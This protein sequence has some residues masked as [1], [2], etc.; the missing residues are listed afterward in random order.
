MVR[1]GEFDKFAEG[2]KIWTPFDSY[3]MR[4]AIADGF[5]LNPLENLVAVSSKMYFKPPD[6]ELRGF[7]D[8]T[9][10][11]EVQPEGGGTGIDENDKQ[12][13]IRKKSIYENEARIEA[14]SKFVVNI[15]VSVVYRAIRGKDG[16]GWGKA[17]LAVSSIKAAQRYKV[18][19]AEYFEKITRE[20]K[21]KSFKDAPVYVVYSDQ[22]YESA[23]NFNEGLAEKKVLENFAIKKNGIIIV[24]DKLQTG[25]DE[26]KLHTLFLDKEIAGINAIQTISRVNRK[27]KNKHDCRI[28]DFSYKNVNI[29]NI[30]HAYKLFSNVVDSDFA[31]LACED[32][33]KAYYRDLK[34]TTV[35]KATFPSFSKY[36]AEKE[37]IDLVLQ[38][39]HHFVDYIRANPEAAQCLK[40]KVYRYFRTLNTIEHILVFDPKLSEGVFKDFWHKFNIQYKNLNST[41]ENID[42]VA[43]YFDNKSGIIVPEDYPEEQGSQLKILSEPRGV[44][45]EGKDYKYDILRVIEE[46][47]QEEEA[48]EELIKD[49]AE[50]IDWLFEYIEADKDGKR[51]SKKILDKEAK[52]DRDEIYTEFAALYRKFVRRNKAKLEAGFIKHTRAL[53]NHLCVDFEKKLETT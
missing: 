7:E 27:T 44:Y 42:E 6:Q 18:F 16:K 49:V 2:E 33:L 23:S 40:K 48:I 43:V 24:V 3:T 50:K 47:N 15:L 53:T 21:Y 28:V 8:E 9:R 51:L 17:M 52:F 10:L 29:D 36:D 19:I 30:K 32:R 11:Y 37:D 12:Y 1:F 25:F 4:E 39:Q 5:I 31:P 45:G 22:E 26:P 38:T 46:K 14:I 20:K 13:R 35:F 41:T 34:D